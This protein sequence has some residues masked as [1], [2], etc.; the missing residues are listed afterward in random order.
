LRSR[1]RD[2]ID[3]RRSFIRVYSTRL[4]CDFWLV[5][6]G[7]ADPAAEMFGGKAITM[8]VLAE[9]M[10]EQDKS[11]QILKELLSRIPL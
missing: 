4:Q 6:E 10:L 11:V 3:G 7:L 8:Q 5:N 2:V 9:L 1:I